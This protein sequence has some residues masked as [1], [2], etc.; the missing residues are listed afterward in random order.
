MTCRFGLIDRVCGELY[1][2]DPLWDSY[3]GVLV[4]SGYTD[5]KSVRRCETCKHRHQLPI[6]TPIWLAFRRLVDE[7]LF[8]YNDLGSIIRIARI[9]A[10]IQQKLTEDKKDGDNG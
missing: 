6:D 2:F 10:R 4:V 9:G 3:E 1:D 8:D 7:G 5:I